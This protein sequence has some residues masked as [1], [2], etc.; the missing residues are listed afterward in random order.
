MVFI[1]TSSDSNSV[2]FARLVVESD[3]SAG[4]TL[5]SNQKCIRSRTNGFSNGEMFHVEST[6]VAIVRGKEKINAPLS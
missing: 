6:S 5:V 1:M 4:C 3:K 2:I